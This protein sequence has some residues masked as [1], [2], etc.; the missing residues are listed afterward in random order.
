MAALRWIV[1]AC[2]ACGLAFAAPAR[3]HTLD[4]VRRLYAEGRFLEAA[5]AGEAVGSA[6][7]LTLAARSLLA[8]S[9]FNPLNEADAPLLMAAQGRA[10]EALQR[11]PGSVAAQLQLAAA[12]GF[13]A[14]LLSNREAMASGIAGRAQALISGAVQRAPSDPWA[15]ALY[16]G[17]HFET[18][19]RGGAVGAMVM[20]ASVSAGEAAFQRAVALAPRDPGILMAYAT[21][22]L[23]LDPQAN[24]A[25]ARGLFD[26]AA[27]CAPR[28]AF[29]RLTADRAART[30]EVVR[31]EGGRAAA[32]SLAA[33]I[34]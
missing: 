24:A 23:M 28:D 12:L 27:A 32:R 19:R 18:V 14:Q 8:Q 21:A 15:Q 2:V 29:E 3:A 7:A 16:G 22:L 1:L 33:Q 20:G 4:D 34:R 11:Q 9:M 10:E 31:A 6:S 17:W 26:Q 25:R 13:R 5:M 30:S